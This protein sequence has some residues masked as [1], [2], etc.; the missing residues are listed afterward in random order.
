MG[1]Q[2][3]QAKK[4]YTVI[5]AALNKV[6]SL[7]PPSKISLRSL[8]LTDFC[9]GILLEPLFVTL[10]MAKKYENWNLCY[11]I[12]AYTLFTGQVLCLVSFLTLTAISVDR[13]L[14]LLLGMRYRQVVTLKRVRLIVICFWTL[15]ISFATAVFWNNRA[16][17]YYIC[18][19]VQLSLV[20]AT[21]CYIKIYL[22]LLHHQ[23]QIHQHVHQGQANGHE[24][25]NIARYRKTV[26]SALWVQFSVLACYLPFGLVTASVT[27]KGMI[28]SLLVAW[29]LSLTLMFFNSTLNPII[30]CWKIREVRRASIATIR[31]I[32]CLLRS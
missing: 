30:Y 13:L 18:V 23:T 9:V 26:S 17:L 6:S 16:T 5:L 11:S 24:L 15:N 4:V 31:Q 2:T 10:L 19:A 21:C 27:F 12:L 25:L 22:R 14:A 7:H 20:V 32:W 28:P 8:P 1:K 3:A 29:T